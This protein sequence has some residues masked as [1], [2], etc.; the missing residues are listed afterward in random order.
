MASG[1]GRASPISSGGSGLPSR[2]IFHGVEGIGKSSLGAN[3]VK[4]VFSMTKNETGL[5]TLIDNGLVG[6]TPHFDEAMTWNELLG[7]V[8]YLTD[9]D[10]GYKTYVLDTLNGAETLCFEHVCRERYNNDWASFL[11]YGRGADDA[12]ADWKQFLPLLERLRESRRMAIFCLCHTQ[13]KT[14]KNPEGEDYDRYIP[15]MAKGTWGAAYKWCDIVLFG[16]YFTLAKKE[17]G[18]MKAKGMGGDERYIHTTRSAAFDAKNRVG[19]PPRI[20]MGKDGREAWASL[21]NEMVEAKKR[22]QAEQQ[23]QPAEAVPAA[24]QGEAAAVVISEVPAEVT[25]NV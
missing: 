5:L 4:P 8:K 20:K 17:R 7:N 3:T 11:A 10:T 9:N 1:N 23:Q 25:S 16:N 6:R 19:L 18:A 22:V 14:F 15:D 2:V 24:P 12:V 21:R 13:V